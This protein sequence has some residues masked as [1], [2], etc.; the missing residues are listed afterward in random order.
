LVQDPGVSGTK[1]GQVLEFSMRRF[2]SIY[3][4]IFWDLKIWA[5]N[6]GFSFS[7]E[8]KKKTELLLGNGGVLT[9]G[10]Y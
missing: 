10:C 2:G 1:T 7:S 5:K 6:P 8:P 9:L 4:A 3:F